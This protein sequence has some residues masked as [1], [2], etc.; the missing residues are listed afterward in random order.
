MKRGVVYRK[1]LKIGETFHAIWPRSLSIIK[2]STE[3][4]IMA[5]TYR[6]D[7]YVCA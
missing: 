4:V 1:S 5:G 6:D 2:H 3:G 7:A